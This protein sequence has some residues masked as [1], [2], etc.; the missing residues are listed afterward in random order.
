V[1]RLAVFDRR[2]AGVLLHP[3]SLPGGDF[4]ADAYRFVDWLAATGTSVWQMLPLGPTHVDGSPYN[5]LSVHALNP[6]LLS[7][8]QLAEEGWLDD[9]SRPLSSSDW[10]AVMA[11]LQRPEA[12]VT[13]AAFETFCL[14]QAG[15]LEDYALYTVLRSQ[16]G[17]RPW[18]EW[19][20]P[21]RDRDPAALDEAE[22]RSA[23]SLEGIKFEQFLVAQQFDELR[24]YAQ[25]RGVR[26]FGDMPIFVAHDSAEVWAWREFFKLDD[27]G[28][29]RVV[30]GVPPDYFSATGQ[31]WGNPVY[32][33]NRMQADGF[34]WW[35][36]RLTTD[37][38]RFDLL[39]IDH[40]RGFEAGW[41]IPARDETAVHG[42][43]VRAPGDV[44]FREFEQKFG[45]LPMVAEDLGVITPEVTALRDRYRLPGM[46]VLQFAFDSGP[47]NPYLPHN[48]STEAVV[49]TGTHDN[50][51]TLAW[52]DSLPETKRQSVL[53][54]LETREPMPR[55]LMHAALNSVARL[56][57]VPMQDVLQLG[58]GQ[59]MNTP[60]VAAG[61]WRWRFEWDQLST[62]QTA[63]WRQRV[64]RSGRSVQ[65]AT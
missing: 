52:F 50:D 61:N 29:P 51:T 43:W 58:D 28:Q 64:E 39:R 38:S 8:R 59:R 18:W 9:P 60:G 46:L 42:H 10:S 35:L 32:D 6:R 17:D 14:L 25:G 36:A 30:A 57:V 62:D 16:H 23:E 4:G 48:H 13:R 63:W 11:R 20:A 22:A 54:Y 3:T 24:R 40:F 12:A 26:L 65:S 37:L 19:P 5:C 34:R 55:V 44:L 33:W 7:A 27:Q 31:R 49:Y 21:L 53:D 47:D 45:A 41:E 15:W 1:S 56:A 2:R